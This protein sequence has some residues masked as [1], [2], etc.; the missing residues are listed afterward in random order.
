VAARAIRAGCA[1]P[2][3]A[4]GNWAYV[5]AG[6]LGEDA[7]NLVPDAMLDD[8]VPAGQAPELAEQVERGYLAGLR[9]GGWDGDERLVRLGMRATQA[10]KYCWVAPRLAAGGW[11]GADEQ[12]VQAVLALLAG[13]ADEAR[14]LMNAGAGPP[15]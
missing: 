15:R 3:R 1:R 10:V 6:A 7:G 4:A 5:G 11:A 2:R 8:F 14:R 13:W 12:Q 9:A